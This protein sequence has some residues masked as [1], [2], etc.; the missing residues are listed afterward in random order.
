MNP[1]NMEAFILQDNQKF[2][3]FPAVI[4]RIYNLYCQPDKRIDL[5]Q[6][7]RQK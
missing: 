3:A 7:R 5:Y 1:S 4:S 6:G 2:H